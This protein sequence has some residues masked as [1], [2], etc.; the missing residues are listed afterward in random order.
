MTNEKWSYENP[1][2]W[3]WE[4]KPLLESYVKYEDVDLQIGGAQ[5]AHRVSS[6][7]FTQLENT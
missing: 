1:Q 3:G 7:N 6:T 5:S 4:Q 2:N